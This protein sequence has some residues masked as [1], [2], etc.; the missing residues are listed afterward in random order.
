MAASS[1]LLRSS[2]FRSNNV[3][4]SLA[5]IF[6]SFS[7]P[8]NS[9]VIVAWRVFCSAIAVLLAATFAEPASDCRWNSL[10]KRAMSV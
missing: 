5:R 3:L 1:V 6:L 8:A 4:R 10:C 2:F 7:I 9:L